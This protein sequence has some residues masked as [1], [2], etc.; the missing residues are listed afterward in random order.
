MIH[1]SP[2]RRLAFLAALALAVTAPA[3][4]EAAVASPVLSALSDTVRLHVVP[5][6]AV[7]DAGDTVLVE[8][9]VPVAGPAFNAYDAYLQYEPAA[10]RFLPAA[11]IAT[12]EGPLMTTGCGL[13]FHVF[14]ADTLAGR[15]RISH[16][17]MCGGQS[18]TGPGVI[19]R[20]RFVCRDVD[21]ETQLKLLLVA[22]YGT[23]FYNAGLFVTPL[24]TLDAVVRVGTPWVAPAPE[25]PAAA[26]LS[27]LRAMPN[28]FNPRTTIAFS[29]ASAGEA[30]VT[31][32]AVDGRLVRRLWDGWLD[33]GPWS[34][35][36]DGRDDRGR[37]VAAGIYLVRVR[38]AGA[39][40]ATRVALVR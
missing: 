33:T 23:A 9:T 28:P 37:A 36:W 14:Q 25:P 27:N 16:S 34:G 1:P 10:L 11:N 40:A 7:A 21:L 4:L 32:H 29:L 39:E 15:L 5:V 8:L 19:Y 30:A 13:R 3:V 17:L 31:I 6:P 2:V 24:A 18:R 22:P 20:V 35:T 26:A 38:M 12:Q